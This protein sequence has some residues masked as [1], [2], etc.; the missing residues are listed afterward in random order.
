MLTQALT[1]LL[2]SIR[3]AEMPHWWRQ[4]G[5]NWSTAQM[6]MANSTLPTFFLHVYVFDAAIADG[7]YNCSKTDKRQKQSSFG[8][9]LE[10]MKECLAGAEDRGISRFYG[11]HDDEC[12]V[13]GEGG[14]LLCCEFCSTVQHARC[15][16]PP[17]LED[18][19]SFDWACDG[20]ANNILPKLVR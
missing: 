16:D 17:I 1:T 19:D 13:C 2:A 6:L 8:F 10:E 14:S 7:S 18:T 9:S 3:R 20:C 12:V 4:D 15:C 11:A 5:G